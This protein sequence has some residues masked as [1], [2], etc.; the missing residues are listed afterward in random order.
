MLEPSL[1]SQL[2]LDGLLARE[3]ATS[4][5]GAR[6]AA[7]WD[8][9]AARRNPRERDS[10]YSAALLERLD[11][12]GISTALDIGCG[13]GNLAIP[14]ALRLQHVVAL[15]FSSEMLRHLRNNA[16][17]AAVSPEHLAVHQLAWTDDWEAHLQ[18]A[19]LA[20]CSRAMDFGDLRRCLRKMHRFARQRCVLVLHA[21]SSYLGPDVLRLLG[22][23]VHP[24]A[25]YIY[26][27]AM[28]HQMGIRCGV[29]FLAST[30]GMAYDDV[31]EFVESVHW[32]IGDL[33][34]EEVAKLHALFARLPRLPDGRVAYSHPFCWAIL[35]WS[36]ADTDLEAYARFAAFDGPPPPEPARDLTAP[37]TLP[38]PYPP[39]SPES[40]L[41]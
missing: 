6:G 18:P 41:P 20:L 11:L 16:T 7:A 15:D 24:R 27:V 21:G 31:G 28:L 33:A 22:R 35:E 3:R 1:F 23:T 38:A 4:S 34:P 12:K 25:D 19:D 29:S 32:R 14:L 17:A 5:F 8:R 13:T 26:A 10:S 9:R 39:F 36:I 2:D 37:P 30:G 40:S